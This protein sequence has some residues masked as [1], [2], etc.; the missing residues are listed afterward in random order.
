MITIK[1]QICIVTN[2]ASEGTLSSFMK[3]RK[4]ERRRITDKEA[5]CIIK[6][7]LK[8]VKYLHDKK[9]IHRDLK[10]ANILIHDKKDFSKIQ[11]IDFGFCTLCKEPLTKQCGT[12]KYM[13]PTL[14]KRLHYGLPADIWS[15]GIIMYMLLN[16]NRHPF[17]NN[18]L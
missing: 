16:K 4:Q 8:A 12:L 10:P 14:I 3:K 6:H 15:V 7:I 13:A 18:S 17:F 11:L 5:C 1:S 9:L 2:Y